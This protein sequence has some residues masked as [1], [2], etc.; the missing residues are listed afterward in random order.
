MDVSR[1]TGSNEVTDDV[2]S[3][4]N[5]VVQLTGKLN[6]CYFGPRANSTYPGFSDPVYAEAY[7]KVH[8]FDILLGWF[9]IA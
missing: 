5:S 8:G 3:N 7:V 4:L 9:L 1:A 2:A 6:S